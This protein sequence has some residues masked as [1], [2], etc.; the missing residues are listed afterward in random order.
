MGGSLWL[1]KEQVAVGSGEFCLRGRASWAGCPRWVRKG[2]SDGLPAGLGTHLLC[3]LTF[4]HLDPAPL[5]SFPA[6]A[7]TALGPGLRE[8][9]QPYHKP[10][11]WTSRRL[12]GTP[13][14]APPR[15][16][17]PSAARPVCYPGSSQARPGPG[18]QVNRH[19]LQSSEEARGRRAQNP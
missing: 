8:V 17:A 2:S 4:A 6:H 7:R 19:S 14:L 13:P 12:E 11:P 3:R 16:V 5:L 10:G 15:L 18:P 9:C 1:K